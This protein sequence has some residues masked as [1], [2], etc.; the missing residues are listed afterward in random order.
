VIIRP[1]YYTNFGTAE[2]P[3]SD[4]SNFLCPVSATWPNRVIVTSGSPNYAHAPGATGSDDGVS[5]VSGK[6]T[7]NQECS[8]IVGQIGAGFS[9]AEL[10][11]HVLMT[12]VT[13]PTDGIFSYEWDIINTGNASQWVLW[14]GNPHIGEFTVLGP[15]AALGGL[16][17]GD[18]LTARAIV[19]TDATELRGYKN[20]TLIETYIDTATTRL[21]AGSPGIAFDNEVGTDVIAFTSYWAM[22]LSPEKGLFPRPIVNFQ[23]FDDDGIAGDLRDIKNWFKTATGMYVPCSI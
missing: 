23:D 6:W 9:A 22:S 1:F 3:L 15:G 2:S 20:G 10:E 17:A 16:V 13:S 7:P 19:R 18:V 12:M 14:R 8:G 11:L 21:Q 4:G 5:I